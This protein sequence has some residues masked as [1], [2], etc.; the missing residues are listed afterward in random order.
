L[1]A[2]ANFCP[3]VGLQPFKEEDRAYF[4]GRER[5]IRLVGANLY[6]AKLTVLYGESGVGKSSVLMAGVVP[7]L[8]QKPRTAVMIFREWQR[9]DALSI[10]KA[11]IAHAADEAA[12][13]PLGLD[14]STPLDDLLAAAGKAIGGTTL[15]LMDQFEEYFL[16]YPPGGAGDEFD[17]ELARAV[18][19]RDV[20]AG[21]VLSIRED[22]L[23]K[24]D[25][26]RARI[27]TV[28]ANPLRI[29]H[30]RP[31]DARD[32]IRK[33][34]DV[35]NRRPDA[36]AKPVSI[37]PT[38]V[39]ALIEQTISGRVSLAQTGAATDTKAEA[40]ER[41]EAPYL[42]L[43]LTRLWNEEG[44]LGS[45]ILR[46]ATLETLGGA[47]RIVRTH[48]DQVM[49]RL[50]PDDQALCA[51][52][53]DRLVT[54]SGTKIACRLDDLKQWA[55]AGRASDVEGVVKALA[56]PE[57]RILR[58]IDPLP[59]QPPQ[60]EIFHD[61]LAAGVLDWRSRF[62]EAQ[63]LEEAQA[64]AQH[65]REEAER[66]RERAETARRT[67]RRLRA[68]SAV[69]VVLFVLAF[70]AA[71][72]AYKKQQEANAATDEAK[73]AAAAASAA[74]YTAMTKEEE[75]KKEQARAEEATGRAI[76]SLDDAKKA[77]QKEAL[78]AASAN[79][80]AYSARKANE[81]VEVVQRL[82]RH[83]SD[84]G[85]KPQRSLLLSVQA[86]SLGKD[87]REGTLIAI[88]GLRQQ[89]RITG[90]RPLRGHEK[91]TRVAAI[92]L[93]RRWLATASDDGAIRLW[94]LNT[95]DPT[96]RS[97][98]LDGHKGQVHGLA[99]T[100]DGRWLVSG[101]ADGSVRLWRLTAEGANLGPVFGGGRY[102][103]IQAVAISPKGD[104][105][106]FG[107]KN[108]NICIWKMS[109]DGPLETP[110][111]AWK[112]KVPIMNV[113][114]SPKG[115]WLATTC[116][117][118][119]GAF[120]APVRLWDLSADFPNQEPKRLSHVTKLN[121][122]SLMA[123]AFNGDDTRLAVAYG[124]VAEVWNLTRNNPPQHVVGSYV[125][126]GGWILGVG[127]SPDNRWLALGS[128]SSS[129]VKLW[130]LTGARKEPVFLKGHSAAVNSTVFS[131]DSR[132]L[133]TASD[134][135][136]ARL[137]DLA[138]PTLPA[139]LLRGQDLPVKRVIFSP[140]ADPR[141]LVTAGDEPHARFWNIPDPLTDPVVLRGTAK[142]SIIGMVV[143]PD[144]NWIATS[145]H[146]DPKLV[147]WSAKDPRQ[148]AS[149]LPL[150]S[151][152]HAIA[153]SPDGRW[154]AAKSQEKGVISLW[155]FADRSKPPLKFREQGWGDVRTLGF[156]PD[157]RWLVSGTWEG[158]VNMW[159]TSSDSPSL[160]PRHRCNQREPV[161]EPAFSADGRYVATAVHGRT[162]RLWDLSSPNP[163][164][165]PLGLPH[166]DVVYQV[167]FSPDSRW[168]AT[169]SIDTKGRLWDLRTG[170]G[171]K[172]I[173]ELTF[174][175]RVL[176]ATFS[177]DNRWVAF[178]SW[179]TTLKLLDL[180]NSRTSKPIELSG[181]AGR[182]RFAAF[183]PD[184]K[185]L[186]TGSEDRTI[187]L[188]DPAHPGAAPVVL[189]GHE[190]SVEP[191]LE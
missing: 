20:N 79:R 38:L 7:E 96:N 74:Q 3:Y 125:S 23:S 26:F 43:V 180:K 69:V 60:Y 88:D 72:W 57:A 31:R 146:E 118:A 56:A 68:F 139:T 90:G 150:P 92:S 41:V 106:V 102:G 46:L 101:A 176:L 14:A 83:T 112:D 94:D 9:P 35:Y 158:I 55:G 78:A 184:G 76:K 12:G 16:Y 44:G 32:A 42:Q 99:F 166:A 8:R 155:N 120:G 82:A 131:D 5:E 105:L 185:W 47:S 141:H 29:R 27:P 52:F 10:L 103:A 152:S 45:R 154:L 115:R 22:S 108:G 190:G 93:D 128:L 157:S 186:V 129:D 191:E 111:D 73:K 188:W 181:H 18:N 104:W 40:D 19:R 169:A 171:P 187:R 33:P 149:E 30:L 151:A 36:T 173:S 25:R 179:D 145:S 34:L 66:E 24:L 127:L 84:I 48:L 126:S 17:A 62:V 147:L 77:Q 168:A 114:F 130:D 172:L 2:D 67:A 174:K 116:T 71:W 119:C 124:Y 148:P 164:A 58:A 28:L 61:V 144:G 122:D 136:T 100:P 54:P 53:F 177:P 70:G 107:T 159:E 1:T 80:A 143:S 156:S 85:T 162:A 123:I 138:D 160:E 87:G 75:A 21:F 132:W 182:I 133:A 109:T 95:V 142:P 137:W 86:A 81:K 98:L 113:V 117:G 97:F 178:G 167:A 91:A 153:F 161:R 135:A 121:E 51:D 140:R 6:A 37:E 89:L 39:D 64:E 13:K 134:D 110:C 165:S 4:F 189:R 163:C 49:S 170:F 183:S 59:G 11:S 175:D 63:R 15:V 50:S 65:Q